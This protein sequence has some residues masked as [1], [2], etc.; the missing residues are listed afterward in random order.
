[1]VYLPKYGDLGG[2]RGNERVFETTHTAG[3]EAFLIVRVREMEI[4]VK[5]IKKQTGI[6]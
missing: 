1:M 5:G 4:G 6:G 3:L 2:N